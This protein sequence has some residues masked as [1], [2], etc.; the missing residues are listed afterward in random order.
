MDSGGAEHGFTFNF[1][2]SLMVECATRPS[3]T[4]TGPAEHRPEAEQCGW[5]VD[6]FGVSWQVVPANLAELMTKPG[7]TRR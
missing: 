3:S 5:C 2:V 4:A 1:G 7:R 6:K